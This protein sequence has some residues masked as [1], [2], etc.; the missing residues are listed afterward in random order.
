MH[1]K[2]PSELYIC[3]TGHMFADLN[4]G[5]I[6]ALIPFL[7]L[8][9]GFNYIEVSSIV[10]ATNI[11]SAVIQ[12]LFGWLGDRHNCPWVMALGVFCACSGFAL[13]GVQ[14]NLS[15]ILICAC[16]CGFGIA[17][18]HPE[19]GKVANMVTAEQQKAFG[20]SI[21]AVG[22]NIGFGLGPLLVTG[23]V[24]LFGCSSTLF[25]F[26][27]GIVWSIIMLCKLPTFNRVLRQPKKTTEKR[28]QNDNIK[29]FAITGVIA[30]L[31]SMIFFS[32]TTFIPLFFI[33]ILNQPTSIGSLMVTFFS[34]A[35][36]AATCVGG[37]LGD[38]YG[39]KRLICFAFTLLIPALLLF[40]LS[41]EPA[42]SF[43]AMLAIAIGINFALSPTTVLA[44]SFLPNH[45]GTAT[46]LVLGLAVSLG[47][48]S[49][50]VYGS[51]GQTFSLPT[52]F[53]ILTAIAVIGLC[54]ARMIP[55]KQDD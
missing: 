23:L 12:P 2:I 21:F 25:F 43:I 31:R 13:I 47:G 22:G 27:P 48:A 50:M 51:I 29:G 55:G 52:V 5:A 3:M 6:P 33:Q 45:I 34:I 19:G 15:S 37:V 36:I 18:F 28:K 11:M 44:Q 14:T 46:G 1:S 8:A 24:S 32:S 16:I 40:G 20:M 41:H 30:Y 54:F 38:K 4:Q 17:L 9:Q 53:F 10:L 26:V 42:L 49:N 39:L 35:G 7:V